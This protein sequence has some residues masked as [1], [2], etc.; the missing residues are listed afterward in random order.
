MLICGVILLSGCVKPA[1]IDPDRGPYFCDVEQARR[2]ASV[3]VLDYRIEHDR[4]E[5]VKDQQT[6]KTGQT[7][8]EWTP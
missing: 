8:C 7:Y 1:L 3:K 2:P 5:V 6:N 4:A